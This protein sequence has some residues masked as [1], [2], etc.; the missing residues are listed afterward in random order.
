MANGVGDRDKVPF[1]F[2]ELLA[3]IAPRAIFINAPLNDANF[4]VSGVKDSLAAA[5]PIYELHGARDNLRAIYP[6]VA[7]DFPPDAREQAYQF[8]DRHLLHTPR[9]TD[10]RPQRQ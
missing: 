2:P 7:H 3:A 5:E 4:E 6:S 10:A 1:D 9:A 8:L